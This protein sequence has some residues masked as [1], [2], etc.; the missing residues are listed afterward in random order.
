MS[1]DVLEKRILEIQKAIQESSTN[2]KQLQAAYEQSTAHHNALLGRLNE[3][4][5]L[6]SE[7][8]TKECASQPSL[9][10]EDDKHASS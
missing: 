6:L 10:S 1:K 2:H 9:S 5:F 8:F 4:Q 7:L 3:A